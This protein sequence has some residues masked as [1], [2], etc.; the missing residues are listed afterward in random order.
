MGAQIDAAPKAGRHG[1]NRRGHAVIG[2]FGDDKPGAPGVRRGDPKR[3]IIGLGPGAGEH[4]M[5]Q[6]WREIRQQ[7]FRIA[8]HAVVQIS[9]MAGKNCRLP[10]CRRHHMRVAMP[11]RSD[12]VI[13]IQIRIARR[14]IKPNPLAADQMHRGLIEQPIGGPEE[15]TP[16]L[17]QHQ[18]RRLQIALA[19]L[20]GV[21][22]R[23]GQL[24]S[25][26][27]GNLKAVRR[28]WTAPPW[29]SAPRAKSPA[30][31]RCT[32]RRI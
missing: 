1:R 8:Q 29:S 26:G 12:V 7:L 21:R 14:I 22:H 27:H 6:L 4:H 11:D 10:C 24:R 30:R 16:P 19:G 17:G 13:G 15:S 25:V 31:E 5:R 20:I 18:L 28:D 3:Q 23:A 2:V 9:G 32:F